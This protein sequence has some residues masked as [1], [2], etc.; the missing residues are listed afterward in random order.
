V[1]TVNEPGVN[2]NEWKAAGKILLAARSLIEKRGWQQ[3]ANHPV[4]EECMA[5][6]LEH[7]FRDNEFSIVEFNYAREALA[8]TLNIEREP[9]KTDNDPLDVPYWGRPLMDWNDAPGRT[10][11]EVLE[12]FKRAS[13]LSIHLS[14]TRS[15][16]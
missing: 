10:K 4:P 5:T 7:A 11:E 9:Q 16:S 6:A 13:E 3:G 2:V 15:E 14:K 8:R 12:A 1:K